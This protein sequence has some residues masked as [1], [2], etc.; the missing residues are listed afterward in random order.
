MSGEVGGSFIVDIVSGTQFPVGHVGQV[1]AVEVQSFFAQAGSSCTRCTGSSASSAFGTWCRCRPSC[2]RS[3]TPTPG[4]HVHDLSRHR[5]DVQPGVG[6]WSPRR[7]WAKRVRH[8]R[9]EIVGSLRCGGSGFGSVFGSSGAVFWL[10]ATIVVVPGFEEAFSMTGF[11]RGGRQ[12]LAGPRGPER[13]APPAVENG[14]DAG[15]MLCDG[16]TV[17][18]RFR[19]LR[20]DFDLRDIADLRQ[21]RRLRLDDNHGS[22]GAGGTATGG[23]VTTTGAV[24]LVVVTTGSVGAMGAGGVGGITATAG[25][26]GTGGGPRRGHRDSGRCRSRRSRGI[27]ATA[28]G[29]G[30]GGDRI[31]NLRN[32]DQ[33]SLLTAP[34]AVPGAARRRQSVPRQTARRPAESA[35]SRCWSWG[36]DFTD[37]PKRARPEPS[38]SAKWRRSDDGDGRRQSLQ[39]LRPRQAESAAPVRLS[40]SGF[41]SRRRR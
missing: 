25:G 6:P 24:A 18:R 22:R 9:N 4:S 34:A 23:T 33:R 39:R 11:Q 32:G 28:G 21:R 41:V 8:R 17:R 3:E 30:A 38:A 15:G 29:V 1:L 31:R 27:T 2:M 37:G 20:G 5:D 36:R 7:P 14:S 19:G 13:V 35:A 16:V 10:A 40:E 26:V 12:I